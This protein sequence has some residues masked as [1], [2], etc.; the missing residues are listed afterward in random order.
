MIENK[1]KLVAI[2]I[3]ILVPITIGFYVVWGILLNKG[4]VIFE[5]QPP[6]NVSI[7][8]ENVQCMQASCTVSVGKGLHKYTVSKEGYYPESGSVIVKRGSSETIKLDLKYI[9]QVLE[10]QP[11][12]V[13]AL[14]VGY[15]KFEDRLLDVTLFHSFIPSHALKKLPKK[16]D[17]I[18]L[19]P[20]GKKGII[21][22]SGTVSLYDTLEFTM[23]TLDDIPDAK[24]VSWSSDE[25]R[26]YTLSFDENSKRESL[27]KV[28][29][30]GSHET[31]NLIF[32]IR[33]IDEYIL[34]VSPDENYVAV[35]DKT[36]RPEVLYIVDLQKESR[37]NVF[38]GYNIESSG[39]SKDGLYVFKGTS[40][41]DDIIGIWYWDSHARS[42]DERSENLALS[43]IKKLPFNAD[44]KNLDFGENGNA[45]FVTT[46]S[47]NLSG[48]VYPYRLDFIEMQNPLDAATLFDETVLPENLLLGRWDIPTGEFYLVQNLLEIVPA[49]PDKIEIGE[50]GKILRMLSGGQTFDIWLAE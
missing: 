14:P 13:F 3:L 39:W 25:S 31:E 19:S 29:L 27:K 43:E 45:Y 40:T 37:T 21:F 8:N 41:E 28:Y 11:Y 4:D 18:E 49:I 15:F 26:L 36:F 17:D 44:V 23:K 32:F 33:D 12:N 9:I 38:E 47:Y 2:I 46:Q 30:D 1:N 48:D 50:S 22:E 16:I 7:A 20:S 6:F 42:A 24:A 35:V 10:G 5:G 34:S